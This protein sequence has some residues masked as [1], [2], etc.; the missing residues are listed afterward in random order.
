[1]SDYARAKLV[2][3]RMQLHKLY[4]PGLKGLFHPESGDFNHH[5]LAAPH[6]GLGAT[7]ITI[8]S[9]TIDTTSIAAFFLGWTNRMQYSDSTAP[10]NCFYTVAAT[11]TSFNY[12]TSDVQ[13]LISDGS[14]FNLIFYDPLRVY[15]N[16]VSTYE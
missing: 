7:T 5:S 1:M 16:I 10:G 8:G 4:G 12:F 9:I 15:S 3:H 13:R 14:Y 2:E 6:G 11:F